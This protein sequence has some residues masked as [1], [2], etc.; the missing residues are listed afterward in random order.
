[1]K[2]KRSFIS[3]LVALYASMVM[4][5]GGA[6]AQP[7]PVEPSPI[8]LAAAALTPSTGNCGDMRIEWMASC[9]AGLANDVVNQEFGAMPNYEFI[10]T[11]AAG[12]SQVGFNETGPIACAFL[13]APNVPAILDTLYC[14]NT[15]HLGELRLQE[16]Q[17]KPD[18]QMIISVL[19]AHEAMHFVQAQHGV[20]MTLI[21]PTPA[22]LPYEQQGD[23]FAGYA[24]TKW[25][26]QGIFAP[27]SGEVFRNLLQESPPSQSH[28]DAGQRQAAF[29]LGFTQGLAACGDPAAGLHM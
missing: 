12:L 26:A 15:V 4:V 14:D 7:P 17:K 11:W 13:S 23:C 1:M 2:L 22:A 8:P 24:L 3:I 20:N 16:I 21:F 18:P 10:P 27:N 6:S 5:S 28:G 19:T 25:I 9:A 29:W